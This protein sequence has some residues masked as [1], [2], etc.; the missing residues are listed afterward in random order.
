MLSLKVDYRLGGKHRY[1]LAE[2]NENL[3]VIPPEIKKCVAFLAFN[4]IRGSRLAGTVFFVSVPMETIE[5]RYFIYLITARHII[6]KIKENS[7]DNKVNIRLNTKTDT[8]DYVASDISQ[9]KFHPTDT[10]VDVAVLPWAPPQDKIDYL[11]IPRSMALTEEIIKEENISIGDEVFLTGLFSTHYGKKKNLPIIRV[12]NIAMMPEEKVNIESLGEIDA[13][14]IESRSIGGLSGSPV[15]VYLGHM[16]PK[17]G[18][19]NI[20]GQSQLFYWLGLMHGH[21][22]I[23]SK[24]VDVITEDEATIEKVNMGIAI[25]IPTSKILEIIDCDEFK[26]IRKQREEEF[27]KETLPTAD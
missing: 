11:S 3:M 17:N 25:V 15:F 13:Y 19:I 26:A 18:N 20:G 9:W 23:S 14:L 1:Y 5:G 6:E 8:S 27:K 24:K 12:G 21:W 4:T 22:D 2:E 10:S 7:T 16:R